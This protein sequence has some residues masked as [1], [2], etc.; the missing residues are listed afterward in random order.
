ML[1]RI[2]GIFDDILGEGAG[3][4]LAGE[5]VRLACAALL[6]HCARADGH[7][8]EQEDRALHRILSEQYEL[9]ASE[10]QELIAHAQAR[11]TEAVDIHRF[12][13]VLHSSLDWDGRANV[14][15]QLWEIAHADATI[16]HDE[17]STVNLIASLLDI[18]LS[19]VVRLR[20][21]T[22]SS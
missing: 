16:D 11:E 20:R 18:E 6:V 13:R 15:A 19:E 9:T 8:S 2:R 22:A 4:T 21:R 1:K 3:S 5:D 10:T 12:T 14:V 7:Q 17:R